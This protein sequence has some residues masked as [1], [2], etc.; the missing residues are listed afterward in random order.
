MAL[1][2]SLAGMQRVTR[3]GM[4]AFL[5]LSSTGFAET[6]RIVDDNQNRVLNGVEYVGFPW[7]FTPPSDQSN[8]ASQIKLVVSNVGRSLTQDLENL[9][10][11]T[12]VT[13][14]V[15]LVDVKR[16]NEVVKQWRIP[17]SSVTVD[18]ATVSATC[19]NHQFLKQ[20]AVKLRYDQ[21]YAPGAF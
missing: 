16:P 9:P 7:G 12:K 17:M 5:E 4:L 18:M 8:S 11:N 1:N 10:P 2:E 20:Q 14:K 13:A 6:L 3:D 15:M 21:A 19:G